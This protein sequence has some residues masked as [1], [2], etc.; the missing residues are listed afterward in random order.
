M[1]KTFSIG[2][3]KLHFYEADTDEKP[4]DL[5]NDLLKIVR[6]NNRFEY[7]RFIE[8]KNS[9]EYLYHLSEI[10]GNVLRWL[11]I[12]A[13]ESCLEID[14]ECGAISGGVLAKTNRVAIHCDSNVDAEI[15]AERFSDVEGLEV[16]SCNKDVLPEFVSSKYDWVVVKNINLLNLAKKMVEKNGRIVLLTD[17]R[18]GMRNLSGVKP[19][20]EKEY[21]TGVMGKADAGITYMGLK[22]TISKEE[23]S[24]YEIFY[25]YPDYRFMKSLYSDKHLPKVGELVN[26]DYWFESDRMDLFSEKAAFDKCCEEG[27][28]SEFS[29]S[30]IVV[31]GASVNV[32]Y[33]RFSND[34][35]PE[36]GIYTTIENESGTRIVKKY[37]LSELADSHVRNMYDNYKKLQEKYAGS[38][39]AVNK[40][41]LLDIGNRLA[42]TFEFVDGITLG[43]L[44]DKSIDSGSDDEFFELFD[45]YTKLVGFNESFPFADMDVVFSNI[46]VSGDDWTLIDYEWCKD[47]SLTIKE[48]AYRAMYCYYLEDASRKKIKEDLILDRL[49]LSKEAA[50]EIELD[51][52]AFQKKVTGRK[53]ALSELRERFGH[54]SVNPIPLIDKLRD[55]SGIYKFMIYPGGQTGE[56]SEETAYE[57]KD[58]YES[59]RIASVTVPVLKEDR[60]VRIDPLDST[61]IVVVREAKLAEVD[62]PVENKKYLFSNG[63]RLGK[64]T[65]VF[66]TTDPNLY[67]NMDGFIHDE[68]TFLYLK[69]EIID[70]ESDTAD[71]ITSN[72]KKFF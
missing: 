44:M 21:F 46:I 42:A 55:N 53:L 68:D 63:K 5:R 19:F 12:K 7:Q 18:M 20:G 40:C 57:Y 13:E 61:C 54:K 8:E 33:A 66:D 31:F 48:T 70:L 39:L 32:E 11:P 47:S 71:S 22:N 14:G 34:R 27:S 59:E 26:N 64:N 2:K 56:F 36:F 62:F 29:N 23:F 67:F 69:L 41:S 24:S 60:V 15:I 52:A 16:F 10:R 30:F 49:I 3:V 58:A 28:F 35:A 1:N 17:N 72:I 51:E 25:P 6:D 45:K 4:S 9:F 65:F 37:P 50:E 43:E 38:E